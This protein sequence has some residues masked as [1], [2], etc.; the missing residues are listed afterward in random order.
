[1]LLSGYSTKAGEDQRESAPKSALLE[2]YL[3]GTQL[4]LGL[5]EKHGSTQ[6]LEVHVK[7]FMLKHVKLLGLD[8]MADIE[9]LQNLKVEEINRLSNIHGRGSL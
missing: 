9:L 3:H 1:M 8:N 7:E 4:K 2:E 6:A 5:L